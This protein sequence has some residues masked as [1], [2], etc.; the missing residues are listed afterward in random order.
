M[1]AEM[2]RLG[3]HE[4]IRSLG[5]EPGRVIPVQI[6]FS[7]AENLAALRALLTNML[8]DEPIV[9]SLLGNTLANFD[10]D[11]ELLQMLVAHLVRPED[12]LV[13]EVATTQS[14]GP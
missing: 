1:S 14:I 6:D 10:D 12:R 5:L 7:V 9:F 2:L 13:L 4:P 3:V 11:V 8:E